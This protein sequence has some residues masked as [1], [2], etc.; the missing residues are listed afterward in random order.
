MID[1]FNENKLNKLLLF[2]HILFISGS[3]PRTEKV[4]ES[5]NASH[6]S[7]AV[8]EEIY[9]KYLNL[10]IAIQFNKIK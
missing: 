8:D 2:Y 3:F 5:K 6:I 10:S 4:S 7:F 1:G 9:A